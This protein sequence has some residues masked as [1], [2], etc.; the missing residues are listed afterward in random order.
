MNRTKRFLI[1]SHVPHV[2]VD[3]KLFA[4][5]PY[6]REMNI[7]L[8]HIDNYVLIAPIVQDAL[9]SRIDVAYEKDPLLFRTTQELYFHSLSKVSQSIYWGI[10]AF[11]YMIVEM[12]KATHIHVRCPGN[13][14][15]IGCFA[16]VFFPFKKKTAKYAGN[17]DPKSRQPLSYRIQKSILK[18]TFF[19]HNMQALV[20]GDWPDKTR[21]IKPFFTATYS[22]KQMKPIAKPGFET[23]VNL[24]F[25]GVLEAHKSPET[26]IEVV[27]ILHENG[28][29]V[30]ATL[31]GDGKER[32]ILEKMV[33]SY[34]LEEQ[35]NIL[36]NVPSS[37]VRKL[38]EESHFLVFISRSEGWPK[39]VAEAMFWGCVPLTSR[40]SC[41][42]N[43]VGNN[44]ERGFL[45]GND[46]QQ[47]AA[48]ISSLLAAP[49][50]YSQIS[51]N[52]SAWSRQYTLDY[53]DTEIQK[54]I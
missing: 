3:G 19:T 52:A 6:V 13:M 18:S 12:G 14:G 41:V 16:Q 36:G 32:G 20:Y 1:I 4:Y 47:I 5:G 46:P 42:G 43:M 10:K 22:Q 26:I 31:C 17:W 25:V 7:W 28:I 8:Q 51:E 27:K 33:T 23:G 45:M 40:V 53:F 15:L 49:E 11:W 34:V 35:V 21:N 37:E 24:I 2:K 38:M 39:A 54:V 30:Q 29:Q 44:G 9:P 50:D 48:K